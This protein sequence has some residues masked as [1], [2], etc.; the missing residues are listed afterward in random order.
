MNELLK[1]EKKKRKRNKESFTKKNEFQSTRKKNKFVK[2]DGKW[3]KLNKFEDSKHAKLSA[4]E[5]FK[6]N[7]FG[8][9]ENEQYIP[10]QKKLKKM[11]D[12]YFSEM[13][14]EHAHIFSSTPSTNLEKI[15]KTHREKYNLMKIQAGKKSLMRA[16]EKNFILPRD[17]IKSN[18]GKN[19]LNYINDL[20]N[21]DRNIFSEREKENYE[22]SYRIDKNSECEAP[23]MIKNTRGRGGGLGED[24]KREGVNYKIRFEMNE[25]VLEKI[26]QAMKQI[27]GEITKKNKISE[28]NKNKNMNDKVKEGNIFHDDDYIY[29]ENEDIFDSVHDYTNKG[30]LDLNTGFKLSLTKLQNEEDDIF[31]LKN[32]D[33][34]TLL[35]PFKK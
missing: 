15:L 19:L 27:R 25:F 2:V 35:K 29:D 11:N 33:L 8:K 4:N 7:L 12:E 26:Q 28:D 14:K 22:V 34:A 5:E 24:V 32:V 16:E 23:M 21:S 17:E 18:L 3:Q 20:K 10:L 9:D 6:K 30:K 13:E 31:K 1:R